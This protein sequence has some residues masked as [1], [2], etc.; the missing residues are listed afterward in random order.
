MAFHLL[1]SR[2]AYHHIEHGSI[3]QLLALDAKCVLLH[4]LCRFLGI[5]FPPEVGLTELGICKLPTCLSCIDLYS[6]ASDQLAG[7]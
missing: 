3:Y 7:V 4:R 5:E 2:V 6:L 1:G